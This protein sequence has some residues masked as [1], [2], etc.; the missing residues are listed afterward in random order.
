[1]LR[2]TPKAYSRATE[3]LKRIPLVPREHI[4]IPDYHQACRHHRYPNVTD[5]LLVWI[6]LTYTSSGFKSLRAGIT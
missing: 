1:M 5:Q 2:N 6:S 3:N 4:S